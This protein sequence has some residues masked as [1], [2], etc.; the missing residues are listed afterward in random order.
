MFW[1]SS[2]RWVAFLVVRVGR[3]PRRCAATMRM[4]SNIKVECLLPRGFSAHMLQQQV[5]KRL[6]RKLNKIKPDWY[7]RS[8]DTVA[9]NLNFSPEVANSPAGSQ[10]NSW[11]WKE[12]NFENEM[13]IY[14]EVG[15]FC[16]RDRD[17][18]QFGINLLG[19]NCA[20]L[21]SHPSLILKPAS[22]SY[23]GNL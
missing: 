2:K 8:I 6:Q 22:S 14:L 18:W 11:N 9:F 13:E 10:S 4:R 7:F 16:T 20:S 19:E 17:A 21:R 1:V 23:F 12:W 15:C 5:L 3:M